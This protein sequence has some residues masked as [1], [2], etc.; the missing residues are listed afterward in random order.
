MTTSRVLGVRELNRATL[1]RQL[2]LRRDAMDAAEAVEHLFGLQTQVPHN[3]YMALWSRIEGFDPFDFSRRFEAREFVRISMQRCTIHTV[4]ARDCLAFRPLVQTP[5]D[6]TLKAA[7]GKRLVGVDQD[8]A[9]VLSREILEAN[10]MTFADLGKQ[11]LDEWPDA[12]PA[13]LAMVARHVLPL[14]Q[15]PP[16]GLW[17]QGG[18]V[19][20]TTAEQW[21]GAPLSS[22]MTLDEMVLRYLAAFG[23]A[24]VADAQMW[25]GLT[26]LRE[27]FDRLR[28]GLV[29]FRDVNDVELFDLPDA[30]RPGADV[31]APVRFLPEFDN[32]FIGHKD[33]T[34]IVSDRTAYEATW[35]AN[36]TVPV[37]LLDGFINGTW[38]LDVD[39]KR[40]AATLALR[41]FA[42]APDGWRDEL[43]AEGLALLAFHAPDAL[44]NVR[45]ESNESEPA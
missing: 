32:V 10:P 11:L 36:S 16:R 22:E 5:Q 35:K 43:E 21:L 45:W 39:K 29:T 42:S 40:T 19:R 2:L 44:H 30:P 1:E 23:P 24:S 33:R 34:R 15:I 8:R 20:H 4:T 26:R 12:D 14:V 17:Q 6:R 38:R 18:A 9:A 13:A 37:F 28:A 3:H 31:P 25:S 27:V 41:P 7:W